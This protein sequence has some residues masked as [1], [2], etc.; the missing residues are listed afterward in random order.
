MSLAAMTAQ[1]VRK[2][3]PQPDP[4]WNYIFLSEGT[5]T[6]FIHRSLLLSNTRMCHTPMRTQ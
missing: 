3:N 5:I 2:T 4:P 1:N 6:L